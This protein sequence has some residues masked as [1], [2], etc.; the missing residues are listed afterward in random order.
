MYLSPLRGADKYRRSS[1]TGNI[2]FTEVDKIVLLVKN[3][4]EFVDTL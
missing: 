2:N 4:L 3:I 1:L